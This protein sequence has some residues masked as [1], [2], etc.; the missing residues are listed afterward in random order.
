MKKLILAAN[1]AA[2]KH[3]DQRRK[4]R[5]G[6]PYINHPLSLAFVLT[7]EVTDIHD[8]NVVIAALLH[9]TIEDTQT[10]Q[11][12][13]S[14]LFGQT[15]LGIVLELSDDKTIAGE[16][17]KQFQVENAHKLSKEARLVKLA[18]KICNLRDTANSPPF[19]WAIAKQRDYFDWAKAV[20]DRM[21]GTHAE[22][23]NLFYQAYNRRP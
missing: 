11:K 6:S 20:V 19:K 10:S 22:L 13:I 1:F 15:V 23:E 8:E 14:D 17:R 4:D 18:D 7:N 2:N 12:E 16:L 5:E 3:R 21:E 9:D